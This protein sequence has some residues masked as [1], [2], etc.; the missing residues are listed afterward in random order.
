MKLN[1]YI[2]DILGDF[3]D[4]CTQNKNKKKIKRKLL[5]SKKLK[6]FNF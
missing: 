4:K 1:K 3:N 6:K 5:R 2:Q